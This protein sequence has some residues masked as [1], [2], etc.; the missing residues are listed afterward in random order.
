[1]GGLKLL[2]EPEVPALQLPDIV[3]PVPHHYQSG[4]PEPKREP[5]PLFRID[6]ALPQHVGIDQAARQQFHPAALLAH[7]ATRAAA[8]QTLYVQFEPRLDEREV[9]RPE[10]H[11]DLAPED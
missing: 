2:Q 8:D 9:S 5:T 11:R 1:M 10:P 4:Q 7:R 3:D 6:S